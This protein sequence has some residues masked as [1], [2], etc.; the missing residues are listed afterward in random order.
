MPCWWV[1][2]WLWR[3]GCISQDTYLLYIIIIGVLKRILN[4]KSQFSS[5]HWNPSYCCC[6]PDDHLQEASPSFLQPR[7]AMK[8]EFWRPF[9][10]RKMCFEYHIVIF[11]CKKCNPI[12]RKAF[13]IG[14][15]LCSS[16]SEKYMVP[17]ADPWQIQRPFSSLLYSCRL[18]LLFKNWQTTKK[19]Y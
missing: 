5:N 6:P 3:A 14:L 4:K 18:R 15:F 17:W 12:W 8:N 13:V 9:T 16:S 19:A 11:H 2:W 10:M 1:G 7:K